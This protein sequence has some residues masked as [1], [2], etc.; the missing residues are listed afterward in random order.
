MSG[1]VA[2]VKTLRPRPEAMQEFLP[3]W[4]K[5]NAHI[6]A[7]SAARNRMEVLMKEDKVDP[8]RIKELFDV[9]ATHDVEADKC[10][11]AMKPLQTEA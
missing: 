3:L 6:E 5:R 10:T 1:D 9:A 4:H 8:D 2:A 11:E 7:A